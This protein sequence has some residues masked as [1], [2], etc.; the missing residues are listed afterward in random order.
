[1]KQK[2][3]DRQKQ[4]LNIPKTM[5][6]K[7]PKESFESRLLNKY[8]VYVQCF[9]SEET[10]ETQYYLHNELVATWKESGGWNGWYNL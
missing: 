9:Y 6:V 1:M 5:F 4:K 10:K 3:T 8:G 2:Q 7:A